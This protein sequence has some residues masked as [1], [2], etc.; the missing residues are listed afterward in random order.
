MEIFDIV[1][2]SVSAVANFQYKGYTVS[3]STIFQHPSV[4]F[5]NDDGFDMT[6]SS[7]EDAIQKIDEIVS[8]AV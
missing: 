1:G 6:A 2:A 7:V 5:Y 3:M 4:L 8:K